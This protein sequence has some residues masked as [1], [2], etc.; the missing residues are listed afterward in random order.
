VIGINTWIAS[1]S[2]GGGSVG[3]GFAI[4]INNAKRSINEFIST[5]TINYGWLGVSLNDPDKETAQ[6]LGVDGMRGA[7][8][9]QVFLGSPA[10]KGGIRPGDYITHVDGREVRG[11]NQLTMMVGDLSP[12][13]QAKFT[14]FRDGASI[15]VNVRIEVRSDKVAADGKKLW[16]GV[17]VL[18]LTDSIK[19]S[20]NLDKNIS[21]GLFVAQVTAESP[22][23]VIGL[24]QGDR[25]TAVNG[26]TVKDIKA[27]YKA[28]REKAAK[29]LWFD[30]IR[31]DNPLETL[32]FKR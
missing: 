14:V 22:A 6:A 11:M 8:A 4:P 31:G 27:F 32:K 19:T 21:G 16:P 30:F 5:G 29:E 1:N 25:I 26:E 23:D 15:D 17:V 3:L 28:L 24:K 10:D 20:F 18:P 9:S 13:D 2:S 12:G 7:L